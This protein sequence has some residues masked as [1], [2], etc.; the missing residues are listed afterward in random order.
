[1]CLVLLCRRDAALLVRPIHMPLLGAVAALLVSCSGGSSTGPVGGGG[2][3]Q[4]RPSG[5]LMGTSSPPAASASVTP[6]SPS[7]SGHAANTATASP[8]APSGSATARSKLRTYN[9]ERVVWPRLV[10][11]D[12][13]DAAG[14]P[15]V[16]VAATADV[17]GD[18]HDEVFLV[19][20]CRASTSSWPQWLYVYD[21]L[22][23]P[24]G[25]RRIATLLSDE[26][27]TDSRGLRE[28]KVR[29]S[30]RTVSV[31]AEGYDE[32][33]PNALPSLKVRD[34]FTWNDSRFVRGER[35][36]SALN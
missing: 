15:I 29:T 30:G 2:V 33:D 35:Q 32:S 24:A 4:E 17:T 8:S 5:S 27:G 16:E 34:T 14:G 1:M 21:G 6:P 20:E 31:T 7:R 9:P 26:D 13:A 28:I 19:A 22:A 36:L 11:L 10:K 3:E 18:R 23:G 12:C 25:P